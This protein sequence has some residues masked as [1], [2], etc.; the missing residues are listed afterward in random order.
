VRDAMQHADGWFICRVGFVETIRAVSI[1]GG[2]T[3]ANALRREWPAFGV[4][5]ADEALASTPPR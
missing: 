1:A 4:V 2:P 5:E 3:A